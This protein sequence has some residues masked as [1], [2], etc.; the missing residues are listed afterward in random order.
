M[1]P[2]RGSDDV[3]V[4]STVATNIVRACMDMITSH[5]LAPSNCKHS[6]MREA[7]GKTW[8][9]AKYARAGQTSPGTRAGRG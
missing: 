4:F 9:N 7:A 1:R 5:F 2:K 6:A 8:V 3:T